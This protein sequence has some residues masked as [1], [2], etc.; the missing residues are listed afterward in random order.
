MKKFTKGFTLI[1]LLVVIAIIG[2]LS[3][4]VL[5]SLNSARNKG[6]D[7]AAKAGMHNLVAQGALYADSAQYDSVNTETFSS[8]TCSSVTSFFSLDSQ[9]KAIIQ[10]I[11]SNSAGVSCLASTT[12]F[13]V[14]ATLKSGTGSWCVDS[15]GVATGTATLT[16]GY[17]Q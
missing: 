14:V 16:K 2:I 3:S 8:T 1:E 17:C 12:G 6:S 7:A 15:N 4:V 10:N 13:A 9:S 5:A 11:Q